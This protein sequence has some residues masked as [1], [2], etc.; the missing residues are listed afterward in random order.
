MIGD[1]H[2]HTRLS[3]GSSSIDDLI[4]YAKRAGLDF[5]AVTDQDT[6]AGVVRAGVLGRRYGIRII[7]GVEL[8]CRDAER[9]R[10]VHL[11]C[12]LPDKPDRLQGLMNRSLASRRQAGAGMIRRVTHYYPITKEH[13]ARYTLG[14]KAVYEA[15]IMQALLDTGYDCQSHGALYRKLFHPGEGICGVIPEFP[16]VYT[17]LEAV[18]QAGGLA[19][20]AHPNA[21]ASMELLEEL[22]EKRLIQGVERYHP[23]IDEECAGRIGEIGEQYGLFQ[24]GGSGFHGYWSGTPHPVA[25]RITT[26]ECI[27][28][29]FA[30]KKAVPVK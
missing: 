27:R 30:L 2:C 13:I 10:P 28:E 24:T 8:S 25:S 7:P 1:L 18:R 11:L 20:L 15:H 14:S 3:N 19:V 23:G 22:A 21:P 5:L 29:M 17:V 9:D 12:Y 6:M 4:F 16:D 26:E